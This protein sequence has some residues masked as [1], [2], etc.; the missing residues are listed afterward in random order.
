[1]SRKDKKKKNQ[2]SKNEIPTSTVSST[3]TRRTQKLRKDIQPIP[4]S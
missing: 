1:M 3:Y 4:D 2:I